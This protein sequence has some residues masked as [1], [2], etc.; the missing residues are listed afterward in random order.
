MLV[1]VKYLC[2]FRKSQLAGSDVIVQTYTLHAK[3]ET[4]AKEN[5]IRAEIIIK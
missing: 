3:A 4:D 1:P 5:G 2:K